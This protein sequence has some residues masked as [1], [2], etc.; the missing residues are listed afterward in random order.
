MWVGCLACYNDGSLVGDWVDA[1][2]AGEHVPC[3]R[4]D[5]GSPHEEWWVMDFENFGGF[6]TRE[7]SPMEAQR[8]AEAIA[9]IRADG[10]D[11]D[12]VAA[13]ADWVG[14]N[15]TEWDAPTAEAFADAYMGEW[16]SVAEMCEELAHDAGQVPD[17]F[18]YRIDWAYEA[19]NFTCA[20]GYSSPAE[21]GTVYVFQP[22]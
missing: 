7:C 3:Q 19:H 13:W 21:A 17:D 6:L 10:I 8:I 11:P 1:T 22:V 16:P 18:P 5:L 15:V 2:E 14:E 20:G 9:A 4:S 12:A